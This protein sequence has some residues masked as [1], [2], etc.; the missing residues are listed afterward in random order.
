MFNYEFIK[1]TIQFLV[2]VFILITTVSPLLYPVWLKIAKFVRDHSKIVAGF[3]EM[4]N[5]VTKVRVELDKINTAFTDYI[6]KTDER[7]KLLENG[8][9]TE[10][11]PPRY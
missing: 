6:D 8:Y 10:N 3:D 11:K 9:T 1:E 2:Q 7:L 4:I 5:E